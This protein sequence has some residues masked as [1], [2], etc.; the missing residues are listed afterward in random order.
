[1]G[2]LRMTLLTRCGGGDCWESTP[3]VP[4]GLGPVRRLLSCGTYTFMYM[5]NIHNIYSGIYGE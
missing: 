3:C 2:M 1:M 4:L 5:V